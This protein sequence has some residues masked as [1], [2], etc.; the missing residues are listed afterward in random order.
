MSSSISHDLPPFLRHV[1]FF[2]LSSFFKAGTPWCYVDAKCA[3]A[4][5]N[6]M[7][8]NLGGQWKKCANTKDKHAEDCEKDSVE[9]VPEQPLCEMICDNEACRVQQRIACPGEAEPCNS[10]ECVS[11]EKDPK[12]K[13]N[14]KTTDCEDTWT[15]K[16]SRTLVRSRSRVVKL[17]HES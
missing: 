3:D 6:L 8:W 10:C 14:G 4:T 7:A 11:F 5:K 17:S 13:G 12:K 15:P 9:E 2:L 1:P 16:V